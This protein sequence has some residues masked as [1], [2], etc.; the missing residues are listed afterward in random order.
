MAFAAG[1]PG[2]FALLA[3]IPADITQCDAHA[4][5]IMQKMAYLYGWQDLLTDLDE[6][7]D[8]TLAQLALFFGLMLGVGGASAGLSN[9]LASK[10]APAMEKQIFKKALTKTKWALHNPGCRWDL[11]PPVSR[12][13]LKGEPRIS[14]VAPVGRRRRSSVGGRRVTPDPQSTPAPPVGLS[15][16]R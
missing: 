9:F 1:I 6:T 2:G 4:F 10:A 13:A 14:A 16:P 12:S 11:G 7:D 8:D 5:R 15:P 3:T